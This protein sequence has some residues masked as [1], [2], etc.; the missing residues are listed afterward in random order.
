MAVLA[1][2]L[3]SAPLPLAA[4]SL[5]EA[6]TAAYQSNPTLMAARAE[7]RAVNE[8]VPQALSNWRPELFADGS[9]GIQRR[10][11]D[12]SSAESTVPREAEL[13]V[14]QPLYRGGRT[15]AEVAAAEA[16]VRAQR[17]R[18]VST[19]QAVL[20][21]A[22]TTYMDVWRDQA[23]LELN[24]S[25]E[26]VLTRQLEATRDRFEVGELTRTDVAQ[27]ESRLARAT[28]TRIASEGDLAASR[29]AFEEVVGLAPAVLTQPPAL[30]GLPEGRDQAVEAALTANP[31]VESARFAELATQRGIEVARGQLLPVAALTGD[32]IHSEETTT[33][34]SEIQ[35]LRGQ[36]E[37]S[38]PLYQRGLVS[39]QVRE[40]KQ[41]TQQRSRQIDEA[42]RRAE[43]LAVASWERLQSTE[44]QRDAF[45]AE[46]RS[47]EIALEGVR[48]EN[49]VGARTVLDVLDAEQ[50]LLDA[51]VN[52]VRA[53]RDEIV[54][55]FTVISAMGRLTA[56]NL[57]LGVD[58]YDPEVDYQAVR[59][60]WFGLD[61]PGQ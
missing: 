60:R 46:V 49:A 56:R 47:N 44:A 2:G 59:D 54:A 21:D 34:D 39:S 28:A 5:D 43:R 35:R 53:H 17:A 58:V 10:D 20:L 26:E 19:E 13:S 4:Q 33:S 15:V 45:Q 36:V 25:N 7:L 23:V 22:A 41:R 51:Q 40:S 11:T 31:E 18:L 14:E 48:Q 27:S 38:I 30:D 32:A 55:G 61:A 1:L 52:L 29:A 3:V 16:E 9:L 8:G 37:L 57:A 12:S 42:I 6:L 24:E 50:E